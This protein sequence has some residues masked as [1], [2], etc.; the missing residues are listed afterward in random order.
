MCVKHF[1]I[2][3]K[4]INF[5]FVL[6]SSSFSLLFFLLAGIE[7]SI[8]LAGT[9]SVLSKAIPV[10]VNSLGTIT[11]PDFSTESHG[12][13]ISLTGGTCSGFGIGNGAVTMS[14]GVGINLQNLAASCNANWKFRLHSWP[15]IPE[16]SGSASVTLS[17][18]NAVV[19]VAISATADGHP[20]LAA[21]D[22]AVNIGSLNI[23]FSGS[24]WDWLLDLFKDFFNNTIKN[25]VSKA[26]T[27]AIQGFITN[28]ANTILAK[29][30]LEK[31]LFPNKP[32]YNVAE[33]RFGLAGNTVA[34]NTYLGI[35][36]QGDVVL[37]SNPV[38]NP[39]IQPANLPAFQP[40][41]ADHFVQLHLSQYTLLTALSSYY[42]AGVLDYYVPSNKI[43]KGLNSTSAYGLIAPGFPMAY[44]NA[45]VAL[46]LGFVNMPT[47][48]ISPQGVSVDA[49]VS[50]AFVLPNSGNTTAFTLECDAKLSAN[51][52]IGTDSNGD[53]ALVGQLIY[54][55]ADLSVVSSNVGAVTVSLL[56]DLTTY[57]FDNVVI[58]AV[59][60]VI[61]S[62]VPLPSVPGVSLTNTVTR[63]NDGFM[64]VATD[65]DIN[66]TMADAYAAEIKPR[67]Y[68]YNLESQ[69]LD[70]I[71]PS[72]P[73]L[74]GAN[75]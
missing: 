44:P 61:G 53:T 65:F 73:K 18:T 29:A 68:R 10:L 19:A 17:D 62:G 13:D 1:I 35:P 11:I 64:T 40:Q 56:N 71:F 63:F 9:N 28:N 5:P 48:T 38:P 45:A 20:E 8:S 74:R 33:I 57:V 51:F 49:P 47:I 26:F 30:V 52:S 72:V 59:N 50:M 66:I 46:Q 31:P 14:N 25:A 55:S 32:P 24:L 4:Q 70:E 54:L 42:T 15:H 21:T 22:V 67:N 37:I 36:L 75:L 2:F 12:F 58:P 27:G 69:A 16:G 6:S 43:P 23:H 3:V 34:N 41:D 7:A 39:S 60:Q